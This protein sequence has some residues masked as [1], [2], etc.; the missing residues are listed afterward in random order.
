MTSRSRLVVSVLYV[1]GAQPHNLA[2]PAASL[3]FLWW[4]FAR[5]RGLAGQAAAVCG[6]PVKLHRALLL[7][8]VSQ[9]AEPQQV[10]E[11]YIRLAKDYHPDSGSPQASNHKF[12][13]VS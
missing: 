4:S 10:R 5:G 3:S 12:V 8:G 1:F 7:L 11:A 2:R 13:Q 9:H 6:Y